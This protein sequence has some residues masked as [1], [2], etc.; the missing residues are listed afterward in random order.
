VVRLPIPQSIMGIAFC[1]IFAAYYILSRVGMETGVGG[2]LPALLAAWMPNFAL[3]ATAIV[4]ASSRC[5][6]AKAGH[7]R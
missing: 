1:G 5:G 2:K 7:Y 6:P 4:I 3:I